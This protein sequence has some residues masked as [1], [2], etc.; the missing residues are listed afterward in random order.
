MRRVIIESPYAGNVELNLRYLRACM[1]DS[2]MRGEAPFVSHG[3]YTQPGVLDDNDPEERRQGLYAGFTW[4]LVAE[5]TIVYTNLGIT[6]GMAFGI[7]HAETHGKVIEYRSLGDWPEGVDGK[8]DTNY[9]ATV[10][11]GK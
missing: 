10:R 9:L 4:R 1:H 7:A 11:W 6:K 3:L 2:L 8:W 5:A